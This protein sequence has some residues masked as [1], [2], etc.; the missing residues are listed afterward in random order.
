MRAFALTF[1][2]VTAIMSPL[3]AGEDKGAKPI[4]PAEAAKK[5]NEKCTVEMKVASTGKSGGS[6]FLNSKENFRDKD[7][8]TVLIKKEAVESFTKAKIDDIPAH[9]KDK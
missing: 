9:F 5:V 2:V 8:F 4:T 1:A 3:S 6:I 7:N